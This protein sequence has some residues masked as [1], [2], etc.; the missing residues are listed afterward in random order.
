MAKKIAISDQRLAISS[1]PAAEAASP[2]LQS[3]QIGG[4]GSEGY[5]TSTWAGKTIYACVRCAFDSFE[6]EAIKEH[7]ESHVNPPAETVQSKATEA[8]E[9]S[10]S[11]GVYEVYLKEVN[12]AKNDSH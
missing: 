7:V 9:D 11:L 4:K 2:H 5:K 3:A 10:Q 8:P 1:P 6:E 12:D